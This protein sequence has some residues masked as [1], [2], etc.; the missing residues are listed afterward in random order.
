MDYELTLTSGPATEPVTT[1]EAKSHLRVDYSDDDTLIG[2][3]ITAARQY[4]EMVLDRQIITATW[5]MRLNRWPCVTRWNEWGEIR[6]PKP[7]LVSVTSV[8]YV[9]SNGTSQTFSTSDYIV[10]T[11]TKQQGSIRLNYG[12]AWPTHRSQPGAITIVY[13]AGYG[14]AAAVPVV[15]KQAILLIVG[16]LYENRENTTA[17]S[18]MSIPLGARALLDSESWGSEF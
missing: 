8:A 6:L 3:L 16:H 17:Q 4:A 10:F 11:P 15:V 9:D 13:V 18:L 14:A 2:S 1:A 5:S 7:P 12:E